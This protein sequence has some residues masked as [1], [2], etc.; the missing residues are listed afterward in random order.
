LFQRLEKWEEVAVEEVAEPADVEEPAETE[1]TE[2]SAEQW[3][4]VSAELRLGDESVDV[5]A[6]LNQT[7]ILTIYDTGNVQLTV[8]STEVSIL[9]QASVDESGTV[10]V[11][12]LRANL[13]GEVF[14]LAEPVVGE[15]LPSTYVLTVSLNEDGTAEL[16]G[17]WSDWVFSSSWQQL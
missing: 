2:I 15:E 13:P 8:P 16:T 4:L 1:A 14:E 11:E 10:I 3:T 7:Y 9:G 12:I 6:W 5:P 17:T